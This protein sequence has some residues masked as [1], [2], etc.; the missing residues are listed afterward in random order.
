MRSEQAETL[1]RLANLIAEK[2]KQHN[3]TS[4]KTP[5]EIYKTHINDCVQAFKKVQKTLRETVIDCGSGAGLPGLVW[6]ILDTNKKIYT[7]DSTNKKTAFQK[8]AIRELAL[9]NVVAIND[10]IQNVAL[11]QENTVVF[12][13][14]SSVK[15]G[16]LSL[17]KKNN[18]KNI[19]FL[20]KDDE[21]TEQEITEASSLLYDYKRHEYAS[22]NTKMLVLELYDS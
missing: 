7:V 1:K 6:A 4:A 2:N 10:R 3:L 9:E 22:N 20:K 13:A 5:E 16:V 14:F 18:H 17:N 21:K 12:K 19:L 11:D 15:E 8:L